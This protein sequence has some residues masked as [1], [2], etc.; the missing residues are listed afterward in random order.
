M[1]NKFTRYCNDPEL[2]CCRA[3]KELGRLAAENATLRAQLAQVQRERVAAVQDID[4]K[5]V[6]CGK[7]KGWETC[8]EGAFISDGNVC[9]NWQWRGAGKEGQA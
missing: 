3:E 9:L 1:V 7:R 5:C 8:T 2:A 4:R 6:T